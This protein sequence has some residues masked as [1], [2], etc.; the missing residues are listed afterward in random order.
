[1][2]E[3]VPPDVVVPLASPWEHPLPVRDRSQGQPGSLIYYCW[4]V[5]H[6]SK[7]KLYSMHYNLVFIHVYE[8]YSVCIESETTSDGSVV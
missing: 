8:L 5:L 6:T 1:M 2:H 3:K 4:T 7:I